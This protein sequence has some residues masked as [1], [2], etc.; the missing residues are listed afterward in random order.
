MTTTR[1]L[2]LPTKFPSTS[3]LAA[4]TFPSLAS[5]HSQSEIKLVL[6]MLA[7]KHTTCLPASEVVQT[8]APAIMDPS[9]ELTPQEL[10]MLHKYNRSAKIEE[11]M[12][13][14]KSKIGEYRAAKKAQK[15]KEKPE[16][17]F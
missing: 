8:K 12:R 11:N 7:L 14:M 2:K 5:K 15:I 6:D 17:P 4:I 3:L 9:S 16:M 13:D 10:Y 1:L